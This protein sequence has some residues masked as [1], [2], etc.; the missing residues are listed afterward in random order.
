MNIF[1]PFGFGPPIGP[2]GF[3]ALAAGLLPGEQERENQKEMEK[4]TENG[5]VCAEEDNK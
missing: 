5:E 2:Y 3:G 4:K 1:G